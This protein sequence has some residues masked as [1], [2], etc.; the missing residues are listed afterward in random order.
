MKTLSIREMRSALLHL[1]EIVGEECEV[2]VTRRGRPLAR[3][4]PA[5][6][7]TRHPLAGR[8]S[9]FDAE[10]KG[11]ERTIDSPGTRTVLSSP[12]YIDTDRFGQMIFAL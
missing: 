8:V 10:T 3:I 5:P 11:P 7:S 2:V 6:P 1:E 4:L 9:R 12:I